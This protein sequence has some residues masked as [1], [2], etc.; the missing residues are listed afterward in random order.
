MVGPKYTEKQLTQESQNLNLKNQHLNKTELEGNMKDLK[1]AEKEKKNEI[2]KEIIN[3][4]NGFSI[5]KEIKNGNEHLSVKNDTT[6]TKN[7]ADHDSTKKH[8]GKETSTKNVR[9]D[10]KNESHLSQKQFTSKI[11]TD[12]SDALKSMTT[13]S[14]STK[15]GLNDKIAAKPNKRNSE[16]DH[17]NKGN[18]NKPR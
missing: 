12:T 13:V 2:Q 5:S 3:K 14:S 7:S 1:Q 15:L 6:S 11:E 16:I 17:P 4:Q 9:Q 8:P 10:S 18:Y